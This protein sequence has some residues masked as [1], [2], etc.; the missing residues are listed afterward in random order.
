MVGVLLCRYGLQQGRGEQLL[1]VLSEVSQREWRADYAYTSD[2]P[3]PHH[4]NAKAN[5]DQQLREAGAYPLIQRGS[6]QVVICYAGNDGGWW[7][8]VVRGPGPGLDGRFG[9]VWGEPLPDLGRT[10]TVLGLNTQRGP[11]EDLHSAS[12]WCE[13]RLRQQLPDAYAAWA[14]CDH[15]Y[16]I[17]RSEDPIPPEAWAD[18]H[19]AGTCH[20]APR[21]PKCYTYDGVGSE[22][23][24]RTQEGYLRQWLAAIPPE[25]WGYII[26]DEHGVQGNAEGPPPPE[27]WTPEGVLTC[28]PA[29]ASNAPPALR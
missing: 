1:G 11:A 12:H 25:W 16:H 22:V 8:F 14:G 29:D 6:V 5:Y 2:Y 28:P 23:W 4:A 10:Y 19:G 20:Y 26:G 27:G 15:F 13:E 24:G 18:F 17:Y 21:S 7:E 3:P 9:K